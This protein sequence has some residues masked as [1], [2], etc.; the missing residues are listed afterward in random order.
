M[1]EHPDLQNFVM[2]QVRLELQA[3]EAE[4]YAEF[5]RAGQLNRE[6]SPFLQQTAE[7]EDT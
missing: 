6:L 5:V 7:G 2:N 1:N 3:I 4:T